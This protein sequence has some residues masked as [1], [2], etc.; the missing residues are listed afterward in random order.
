MRIALSL[1]LIALVG[2]CM[3]TTYITIHGNTGW[4]GYCLHYGAL[5]PSG[6]CPH[7]PPAVWKSVAILVPAAFLYLF[8]SP[9]AWP[10]MA[11]LWF[12]PV[13]FLIGFAR[14]LE[15]GLGATGGVDSTLLAAGVGCFVVAWIPVIGWRW[16]AVPRDEEREPAEI[17]RGFLLAGVAFV[18]V[19]A[20][21]VYVSVV[22]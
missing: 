7:P 13:L 14:C 20:G 2:F 18:G 4:F 6:L 16:N 5:R 10:M 19:V 3:A 8:I 11:V 15:L 22:S 9:K 21:F 12:W 17:L 1:F